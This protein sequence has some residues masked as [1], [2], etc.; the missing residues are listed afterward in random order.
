MI[1]APVNAGMQMLH[2]AANYEL[3]D[4]PGCKEVRR[5][6]KVGEI[7]IKMVQFTLQKFL[8]IEL[9]PHLSPLCIELHDLLN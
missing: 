9:F 4:N 3:P 5:T 7:S 6:S 8:I 1:L 2:V